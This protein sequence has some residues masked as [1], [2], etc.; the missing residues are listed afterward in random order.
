MKVVGYVRVSTEEQA[1]EGISLEAQQS[2]IEAWAEALDLKV[3]ALEVDAGISG[4]NIRAREGLQR[5]LKL[6]CAEKAALVVYSLSRL[7]RSTKDTIMLAEMLDAAGADLV[8]LS[9]RIDTTSAAGKMVFRVLAMLNEFERDQISERTSAILQHKK[10]KLEAYSPTPYGY[11]KKEKKLYPEPG[12][13][14]VIK[15]MKRLRR[16]GRSFKRIAKYLNCR[17][18]PSKNGSC[19]YASTVSY[20]LNN[21]LHR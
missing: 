10:S 17:K 14:E 13:Q 12:E 6:A 21:N 18:I 20:I 16:Q 3:I 7:S 9:E 2:K 1:R 11:S 5:A 4:K 19:W 15:K 8:S